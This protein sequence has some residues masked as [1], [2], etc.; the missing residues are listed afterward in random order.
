MNIVCKIYIIK[1]IGNS[2]NS[3]K[4]KKFELQESQPSISTG[5]YQMDWNGSIGLGFSTQLDIY[6]K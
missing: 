2:K 1:G 3:D 4:F 5:G 6:T